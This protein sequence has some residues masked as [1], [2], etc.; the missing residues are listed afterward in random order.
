MLGLRPLA[1]Y[2]A[3][4]IPS[5]LP[6]KGFF[7]EEA[8]PAAYAQVVRKTLETFPKLKDTKIVLAPGIGTGAYHPEK[9]TVVL[10]TANPAILAHELGHAANIEPGSVY[11]KILKASRIAN[12]LNAQIAI[13]LAMGIRIFTSPDAA[14]KILNYASLA[15]A[16]LAAPTMA[17][18]FSATIHGVKHSP[19]KLKALRTLVPAYMTHLLAQTM[20]FAV[21]QFTRATL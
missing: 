10:G 13:P 11:A 21:Y 16:I 9:N 17:E 18:E 20:P 4:Q 5:K 1:L 14:N 12:R 8:T 3:P 2:Q 6:A 19:E 15:S 7:G